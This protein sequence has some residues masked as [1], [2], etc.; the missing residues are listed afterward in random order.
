MG[1]FRACL[2]FI[3]LWYDLPCEISSFPSTVDFAYL[4]VFFTWVSC[5]T[6][7]FG[8][9]NQK[10]S[11]QKFPRMTKKR[12]KCVHLAILFQIYTGVLSTFWTIRPAMIFCIFGQSRSLISKSTT[13]HA[14]LVVSFMNLSL[15]LL[16]NQDVK[17]IILRFTED[18]NKRRRTFFLDEF[19]YI[20]KNKG[21][22]II[23]KKFERMQVDFLLKS[24]V[25][26]AVA[27]VVP[28]AARPTASK[29]SVAFWRRG[30]KR[31][32]SLQLR[33]WNLNICIEKV[34]A[35]CWLAVMTLV[36]TSLPLARLFQ[37]LFTFAFVSLIG[38]NLYTTRNDPQFFHTLP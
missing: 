36:K 37:R 15:P 13:L 35:K 28:W 32:E 4:A 31:E 10:M 24:D 25:L 27:V 3:S 29:L 19:T 2:C 6:P 21:L 30:E 8:A 7:K 38:R 22:V 20:C 23:A 34:Y 11:L 9:H 26:T 5:L 16:H 14:Y 1:K 12:I 17:C 33:L 18:V